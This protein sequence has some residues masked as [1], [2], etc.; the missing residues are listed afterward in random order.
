MTALL[1]IDDLRVACGQAGAVRC[2]FSR[3]K[4]VQ[5]VTVSGPN[6][7]GKTTPLAAAMGLLPAR[8]EQICNNIERH[9]PRVAATYLGGHA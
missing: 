2:V 6:G 7:A 1:E 3:T 5:I 4:A 8:G 9:D